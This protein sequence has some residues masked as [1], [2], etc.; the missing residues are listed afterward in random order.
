MSTEGYVLG[1]LVYWIFCFYSQH[2]EMRFPD[3]SIKVCMNMNNNA[4]SSG[5]L[6]I[7][8][9]NIN[10]GMGSAMFYRVMRPLRVG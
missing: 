9:G 2:L 5:N 6:I 1:A 4:A 7:T 3:S 8:I 10:N